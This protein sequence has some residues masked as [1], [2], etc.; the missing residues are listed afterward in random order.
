MLPDVVRIPSSP[1][2]LKSSD[3]FNEK[4]K[5][6]VSLIRLVIMLLKF[7]KILSY[8]V[9]LFKFY[10]LYV[11]L[12]L[13]IS[14]VSNL[15]TQEI[16]EGATGFSLLTSYMPTWN[17]MRNLGYLFAVILFILIGITSLLEDRNQ[18]KTAKKESLLLL[19]ELIRYLILLTFSG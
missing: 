7:N 10:T 9:N 17:A 18:T 6:R 14:I 12:W 5:K 1:Q 3:S 2:Q 4:N 13:F 15:N 11:G 16:S 19:P 8:T